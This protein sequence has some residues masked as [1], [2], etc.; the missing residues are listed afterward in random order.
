MR[1]SAGSEPI[2]DLFIEVADRDLSHK[3]YSAA[4]KH[5]YMQVITRP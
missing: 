4:Y 5:D 3:E 2:E 1:A